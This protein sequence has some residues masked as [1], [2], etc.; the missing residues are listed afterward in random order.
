MDAFLSVPTCYDTQ[1]TLPSLQIWPKEGWGRLRVTPIGKKVNIQVFYL[2]FLLESSNARILVPSSLAQ[3][4]LCNTRHIQLYFPKLRIHSSWL[5]TMLISNLV[6]L[7]TKALF[8]GP[9]SIVP[10]VSL[11][12]LESHIVSYHKLHLTIIPC[13]KR[14]PD[15]IVLANEMTR[16]IYWV[17]EL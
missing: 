8:S 12:Y 11:R 2:V 13:F 4:S 17:E 9:E 5:D 15:D 6:R 16:E 14:W 7:P 10:Q 1:V 3:F